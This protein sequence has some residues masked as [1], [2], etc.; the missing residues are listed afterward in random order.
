[1][2][3]ESSQQ[4]QER[5][6]KRLARSHTGGPTAG[7]IHASKILA[8]KGDPAPFNDFSS[9]AQDCSNGRVYFYG[10]ILPGVVSDGKYTADLFSLDLA[11][12]EWQDLT[13][14]AYSTK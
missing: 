1:M 6:R 8:L 7:R 3:A 9:W 12:M 5:D 13:V 10:G 2:D 4:A 11:S 14:G